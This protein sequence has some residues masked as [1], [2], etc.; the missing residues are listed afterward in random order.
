MHG[1]AIVAQGTPEEI[2]ANP[3]SPTGDYLSGR[4]QIA[5]PAERTPLTGKWL[6][7]KGRAAT[8]CATS[9][10]ICPSA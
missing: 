9:T 6:K 5:I 2:I 1:G 10:W 8:T 3:E 7:L 4:K